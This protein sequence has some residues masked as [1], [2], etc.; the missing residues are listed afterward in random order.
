MKILTTGQQWNSLTEEL[1]YSVCHKKFL[2]LKENGIINGLS[3]NI[4]ID[5]IHI[6]NV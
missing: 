1:H 4:S 2:K 5:I 3:Q 6:F